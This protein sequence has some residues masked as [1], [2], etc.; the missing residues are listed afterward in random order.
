MMFPVIRRILRFWGLVLFSWQNFLKKTT[1]G[2]SRV[3]S[4]PVYWNG[5]DIVLKLLLIFIKIVRFNYYD[6][7]GLSEFTI[8]V[9]LSTIIVGVMIVQ[10]RGEG[11]KNLR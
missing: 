1:G 8:F 4:L 2:Y 5:V 7:R 6:C 10:R 9:D 3:F 11:G